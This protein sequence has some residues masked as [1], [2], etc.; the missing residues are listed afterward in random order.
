MLAATLDGCPPRHRAGRVSRPTCTIPA[1][2]NRWEPKEGER[3]AGLKD[4]HRRHSAFIDWVT[5]PR[6]SADC[7]K[8]LGPDVY[9]AA[10]A[11]TIAS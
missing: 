3:S 9:L 8:L 7:S 10:G 2:R 11:T 4:A 5:V 1:H 6:S